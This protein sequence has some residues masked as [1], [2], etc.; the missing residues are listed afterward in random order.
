M[1]RCADCMEGGKAFTCIGRE[2]R[3]PALQGGICSFQAREGGSL[4]ALSASRLLFADVPQLWSNV[5]YSTVPT[6]VALSLP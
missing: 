6:Y 1:R 4:P 2:D 3:R 5:K